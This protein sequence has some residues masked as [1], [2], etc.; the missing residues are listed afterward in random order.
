M[1]VLLINGSP[2]PN[3]NTCRAL[4]EIADTLK[5]LNID[6]E[7]FWIGNKPVQGCIACGKCKD[8]GV[9]VF[10]SGVYAELREKITDISG[11]VIGSPTYYAGPAGALC[12]LLDRLFYSS[13][14]ILTGVP[15]AAIGIARR[16]GA[17]ETV[18]RLNLYFEINSMPV[19][20]SQYWNLAFGAAE[21]EV[22]NDA[23]GMQTMRTLGRNLAKIIISRNTGQ[24]LDVEKEP[25]VRTNFIR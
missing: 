23:E 8:T 24:S 12:A 18:Q 20:T 7:I 25:F 6:S 4:T 2:R 11:L 14:R 13:A 5:S 9:C 16:A 3:G 1:K 21:G 17:V 19:I 15:A 22:E 10:N